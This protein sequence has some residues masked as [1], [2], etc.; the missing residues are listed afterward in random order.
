[1]NLSPF[2]SQ[3]NYYILRNW[4]QN[5]RIL[6]PEYYTRLAETIG[7]SNAQYNDFRITH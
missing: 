2:L 7:I 4:K 6:L 1:M 3:T 5:L